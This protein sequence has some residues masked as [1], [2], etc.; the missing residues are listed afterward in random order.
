MSAL[1]ARRVPG[2]R[3][4]GIDSGGG[5]AHSAEPFGGIPVA[6]VKEEAYKRLDDLLRRAVELG[7][8]L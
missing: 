4:R 6:F 8:Y 2:I 3:H 5:E 1:G 7:R